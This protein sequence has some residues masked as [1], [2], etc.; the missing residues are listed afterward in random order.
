MGKVVLL[1]KEAKGLKMHWNHEDEPQRPTGNLGLNCDFETMLT[2]CLLLL[3]IKW[4]KSY[5]ACTVS[6]FKIEIITP[7]L[8]YRFLRAYFSKFQT[9]CDLYLPQN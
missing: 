4:G 3:F 2:H 8:Q 7:V 5:Q 6:H 9:V 1:P